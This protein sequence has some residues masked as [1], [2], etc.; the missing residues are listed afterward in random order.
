MP[1]VRNDTEGSR[2]A[3]AIAQPVDSRFD[4][5]NQTCDRPQT[6]S[7]SAPVER[8]R[9]S[10]RCRKRTS[11]CPLRATPENLAAHVPTYSVPD[12]IRVQTSQENLDAY[13]PL[14]A[15]LT[16]AR[17]LRRVRW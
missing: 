13:S 3:A 12:S 9:L 15:A 8:V 16:P 10:P 1:A 14:G 17:R 6:S 7:H 11:I 4:L 5:T 2:R